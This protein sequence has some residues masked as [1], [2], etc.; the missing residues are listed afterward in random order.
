MNGAQHNR[1]SIL[2]LVFLY[3]YRWIYLLLFKFLL[4]FSF[5]INLYIYQSFKSGTWVRDF[6]LFI[7]NNAGM[8]NYQGYSKDKF[9]FYFRIADKPVKYSMQ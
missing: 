4:S 6:N 9:H 3:N 2:L 8:G 5:E 1:K 7:T